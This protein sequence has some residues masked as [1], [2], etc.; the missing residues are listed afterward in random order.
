MG[1]IEKWSGP[2]GSLFL[3]SRENPMGWQQYSTSKLINCMNEN[4]I[5]ALGYDDFG[6]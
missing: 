3:S 6:P 5:C 4:R 1:N 2:A